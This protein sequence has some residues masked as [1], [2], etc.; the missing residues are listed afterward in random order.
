MTLS[1]HI[2]EILRSV[3]NLACRSDALD[4]AG[5]GELVGSGI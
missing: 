3:G 2:V 5:R 1:D 4:P